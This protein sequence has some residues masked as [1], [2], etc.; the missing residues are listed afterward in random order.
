MRA[1]LGE[2]PL[3]QELDR[4]SLNLA[5]TIN[6]PHCPP[7]FT[8][9]LH[10][11]WTY[12]D[13]EGYFLAHP[14]LVHAAVCPLREL[15]L[16]VPDILAKLSGIG[17]VELFTGTDGREYGHITNFLTHQRVTHPTAS[18]IKLLINFPENI[19]RPH[20]PLRPDL[21]IDLGIEVEQGTGKEPFTLDFAVSYILIETRLAGRKIRDVIHEVVYGEIKRGGEPKEIAD[22]IIAAWRKYDA[23]EIAFKQGPENFLGRGTWRKSET[24]WG[25]NGKPVRADGFVPPQNVP[26]DFES[27]SKRVRR[28]LDARKKAAE[29][30]N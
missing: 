22:R 1:V 8:S 24:E 2:P 19:V 30:A 11:F 13:D 9:S 16:S 18:K 3:W 14:K 12:A 20:E 26:A 5:I 21:G 4:S 25:A 29:V 10:S 7:K 17:Y 27:E 28:E 23:M 6:C 15:L